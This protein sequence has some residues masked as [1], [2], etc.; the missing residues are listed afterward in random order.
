VSL[1]MIK[2]AH[3]WCRYNGDRHC[4]YDISIEQK[5]RVPLMISAIQR[6]ATMTAV[7]YEQDTGVA[8]LSTQR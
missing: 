3:E 5:G 2:R 6:V 4:I 1:N 8:I 7:S